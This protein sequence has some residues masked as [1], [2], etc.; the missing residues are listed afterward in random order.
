MK[1]SYNKFYFKAFIL[2]FLVEVAIDIFFKEGFIRH[3]FGDFL[4]VI[5]LYCVFRSFIET[6]VWHLA[7]STLFIAYLIEF[8]QL[9]DF[10]EVIGLA[11]SKW[12]NLIFGNS[13]S[14]G[15][16]AAYSLGIITVQILEKLIRSNHSFPSI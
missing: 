13:F 4:V 2:L 16:L 11:H 15:D 12:A 5:L 1:L 7:I 6:K 14:T 3:T 8:L 9:T 10:L